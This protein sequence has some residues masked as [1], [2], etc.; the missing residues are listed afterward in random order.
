MNQKFKVGDEVIY[1]SGRFI[2]GPRNPFHTIGKVVEINNVEKFDGLYIKVRWPV[3]DETV[4]S[5]TY[6]NVYNHSDLK[7]VPKLITSFN[8]RKS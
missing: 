2:P 1:V 4:F 6:T 5:C 3:L 7:K 8:R